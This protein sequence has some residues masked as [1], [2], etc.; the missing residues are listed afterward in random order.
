VTQRAFNSSSGAQTTHN[1]N[2][3]TEP[4]RSWDTVEGIF[5][6]PSSN[7][8]SVGLGGFLPPSNVFGDYSGVG[9]VSHTVS[10]NGQ[11]SSGV[12]SGAGPVLSGNALGRTDSGGGAAGGTRAAPALPPQPNERY[13]AWLK[14]ARAKNIT[15]K[16]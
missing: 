9:G 16:K 12:S 10:S 4:A 15:K 7:S 2:N 6:A 13:K 1:N 8:N 3:S 5:D 14:Q 11:T